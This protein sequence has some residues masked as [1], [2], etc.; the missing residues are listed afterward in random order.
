[1]L[2]QHKHDAPIGRIDK[3]QVDKKGIFVEGSVSEAAEKLH[4]V[5][6][7][8]KDGALKSFSVGFRVKDGKYNISDVRPEINVYTKNFLA[9]IL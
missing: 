7:L 1:M 2:Y 4:G 6:T 5:Q 9:V 3:I 8:I